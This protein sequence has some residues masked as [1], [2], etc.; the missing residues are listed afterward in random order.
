MLPRETPEE[1]ILS[2]RHLELVFWPLPPAS[3]SHEGQPKGV[4]GDGLIFRLRVGEG[5]G[6]ALQRA[7]QAAPVMALLPYEKDSLYHA[8]Q[9]L[10]LEGRDCL[11]GSQL[12]P[13]Y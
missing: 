8:P 12:H 1:T 10:A 9:T 7:G 2:R 13:Q 4:H 11:L 6:T 3:D 5:T